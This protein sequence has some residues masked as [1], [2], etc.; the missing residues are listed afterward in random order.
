[1][2]SDMVQGGSRGVE[3]LGIIDKFAGNE[4]A[5][6][7]MRRFEGGGRLRPL[8]RALMAGRC[9]AADGAGFGKNPPTLRFYGGGWWQWRRDL[10]A[11]ATPRCP[12]F[13]RGGGAR[14]DEITCAPMEKTAENEGKCEGGEGLGAWFGALRAGRCSEVDWAGFGKTWLHCASMEILGSL[15]EFA[16]LCKEFGMATARTSGR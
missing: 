5:E 10:E 7:R 3:I 2:E 1:M 16:G 13:L 11:G 14:N 12:P 6:N 4:G 9:L 8:S 15:G